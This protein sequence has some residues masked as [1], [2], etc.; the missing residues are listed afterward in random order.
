MTNKENF[1]REDF[2]NP[3]QP[4]R[5]AEIF[6]R[7]LTKIV[8]ARSDAEKAALVRYWGTPLPC[9]GFRESR[10]RKLLTKALCG[11][12]R[13]RK[14]STAVHDQMFTLREKVCC[15]FG[16][17]ARHKSDR[18]VANKVEAHSLEWNEQFHLYE[19]WDAAALRRG[20]SKPGLLQLAP[21]YRRN[22][23]KR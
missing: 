5:V 7:I 19:T 14:V 9:G 6:W 17:M 20:M 15:A 23:K 22:R 8:E 3:R 16:E 18:V 2:E 1:F 13:S 10:L 11:A 12:L 4:V 21:H